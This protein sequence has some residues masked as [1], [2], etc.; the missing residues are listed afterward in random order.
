LTKKKDKESNCNTKTFYIGKS[1]HARA[2]V[3]K[4]EA[5]MIALGRKFN[6]ALIELMD[7]ENHRIENI[8]LQETL[9]M[10]H[11]QEDHVKDYNNTT[12]NAETLAISEN[13]NIQEFLKKMQPYCTSKRKINDKQTFF[14]IQ[15][16]VVNDYDLFREIRLAALK[17][18][19][20]LI[21]N[22]QP[23]FII[24]NLLVPDNA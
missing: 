16:G 5:N 7:Q 11:K 9:T 24:S 13:K 2:V 4:F 19:A 14:G 18:G 22:P 17:V 20:I 15:H 12:N 21:T 3:Q 8:G 23:G 10:N 6:G 1:S